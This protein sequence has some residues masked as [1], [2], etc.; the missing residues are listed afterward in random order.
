ML[1]VNRAVAAS[2]GNVTLCLCNKFAETQDETNLYVHVFLQYVCLC[3]SSGLN[4][5]KWFCCT[6]IHT[7]MRIASNWMMG[8]MG[9]HYLPTP[10]NVF[11]L[12][13]HVNIQAISQTWGFMRTWWCFRWTANRQ[14][15]VCLCVDACAS[16]QVTP[17]TCQMLMTDG[18]HVY[19]H[20]CMCIYMHVCTHIRAW[21]IRH[22]AR[23]CS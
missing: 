16:G 2:S 23:M 15:Y 10:N 14:V 3:L 7:N 22:G 8:S 17:Q 13:I 18:V 6:C 20:S 1:S 21:N 4:P 5:R 12:F 9:G 19:T 11:L